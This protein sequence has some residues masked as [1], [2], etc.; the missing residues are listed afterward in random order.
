VTEEI[1][2]QLPNRRAR[3]IVSPWLQP[4]D[5][6]AGDLEALTRVREAAQMFR[7]SGVRGQLDADEERIFAAVVRPARSAGNGNVEAELERLRG[8]V[9][10]AEAMLANRRF[11]QNAPAHVVEAEREKLARYRRELEALAGGEHP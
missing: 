5:R 8:E 10:R 7:R 3:L 11:V 1:W 4:D 9:A 6:F 2:S